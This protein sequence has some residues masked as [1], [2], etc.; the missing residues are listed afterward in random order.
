[1]QPRSKAATS[2]ARKPGA[3]T[4]GGGLSGAMNANVASPT[5]GHRTA[6]PITAAEARAIIG[7]DSRAMLPTI[8]TPRRP[9]A[10]TSP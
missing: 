8:A 5:F 2:N 6:A 4:I 7:T 9:A 1:M 3:G 10:T